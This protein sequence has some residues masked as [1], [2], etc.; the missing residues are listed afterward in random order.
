MPVYEETIDLKGNLSEE[1]KSAADEMKTLSGAVLA[2]QKAM[3][4]ASAINGMMSKEYLVLAKRSSALEEAQKKIPAGLLAEANAAKVAA[5]AE[6]KAVEIRE[7]AIAESVKLAATQKS[8]AAQLKKNNTEV[9]ALAKEGYLGVAKAAAIAAAAIGAVVLAGVTMAIEASEAR[10][11]M[12]SL[13]DAL[14]EGKISGLE[15]VAMMD[16]LGDSIGQTRAQLAPTI[17]TF[18][19]LGINGKEALEDLTRAAASA[20]AMADGGAE[21]FATFFGQI[22]AAAQTGAKLTLPYKKL[23]KQLLGVGLNIDDLAVK[24]KMTA[25]ALTEGLKKGTVDASK[26]ATALTDAASDKGAGALAQQG[27]SLTN[28]WGKF[29]ENIMRMF[30]SIDVGPFLDQV[31][32][33][34]DIFGQGKASGQALTAGIGGFFKQ[35]FALATKVVPYI[36]RFLLDVVIY[37]L[38]SYIALRPILKWFLDLRN[39]VT[40]MAVVTEGFK[41]VAVAVGAVLVVVALAVGLFVALTAAAAVVGISIWAALTSVVEFTARV[42]AVLGGLVTSAIKLGT[43]FVSGLVSGITSGAGAVVNAVK[44]LADSAKNTFKNVLGIHSPSKVMMELGHYMGQGVAQGVDNSAPQV[45]ASSAG[46]GKIAASG[47]SSGMSGGGGGKGG[48]GG[49]TINVE[50]GAIVIEG[51]GKDAANLTE[52]ALALLFERIALMEGL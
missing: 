42:S 5:T 12:V 50:P 22:D 49:V 41:G 37:G 20:G 38:K 35:V 18:L 13:F 28:V 26:F 23:E 24:M 25:K 32:D 43:D 11:K 8:Q 6:T 19:T 3:L 47:A 10:A 51:G 17:Q 2:T 44:G 15:T 39:N 36:R 21:K 52:E 40:V 27:R 45:Q 14:G 16:K 29:Q 31:K 33:L 48:G 30:E 4:K 9:F 7:K 34:F 1:A 46:L